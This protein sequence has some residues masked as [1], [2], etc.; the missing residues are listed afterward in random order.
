MSSIELS[1]SMYS[2]CGENQRARLQQPVI[3]D[4]VDAYSALLTAIECKVCCCVARQRNEGER[5]VLG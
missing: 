4:L 2:D 3:L 5:A 1:N